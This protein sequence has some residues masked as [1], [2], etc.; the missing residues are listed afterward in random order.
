M[1]YLL[2]TSAIAILLAKYKE[3]ALDILKKCATLDLAF[4]E[5]GNIIWKQYTLF[6]RIT[7][8]QALNRTYEA[9][10]V[11]QS[12]KVYSITKSEEYAKI[13][14]TATNLKLTFY[15]SAFLTL[16]KLNR[17]KLVTQDKELIEKAPNTAITIKEFL[18]ETKES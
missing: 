14:S 10:T 3:K 9:Y 17:L 12:M 1:K 2:D 6:K 4:Y 18:N 15:D 8:K 5:L 7:L 16:S 13:M 11:L